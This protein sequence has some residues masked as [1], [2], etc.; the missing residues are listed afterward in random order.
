MPFIRI[1]FMTAFPREVFLKVQR[2][3]RMNIMPIRHWG[4]RSCRHPALFYSII[5]IVMGQEVVYCSACQIRITGREFE[6]GIAF[7]S[8]NRIYCK[9]C[10]KQLPAEER[11]MAEAPPRK[12][13]S[14][15]APREG[16]P[17]TT[18]LKAV[19]SRGA[20]P[21]A[22]K[23]LLLLAAAAGGG[24]LLLS[25]IVV[26]L[27]SGGKRPPPPPPPAV[28][29]TASPVVPADRKKE[30][31]SL[32]QEKGEARREIQRREAEKRALESPKP[33]PE[34]EPPPIQPAPEKA[35]EAPPQV[36]AE[37]P[38]RSAAVKPPE[39]P[40]VVFADALAK[41][42]RN[43]S[44]DSDVD[45]KADEP[46]PGRGTCITFANRKAWA[47]LYL[48]AS[49]AINPIQ[50]PIL[51]FR[52]RSSRP[53]QRYMLGLYRTDA[54]GRDL[55]DAVDMAKLGGYPPAGECKRYEI[56]V[57]RLGAANGRIQ[58]VVFQDHTGAAQPTLY[59]DDLM[60]LPAASGK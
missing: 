24:A 6:C 42:W 12:P 16:P 32:E 15:T 60:F 45:L 19:P 3:P 27:A 59:V 49:V 5:I 48:R 28:P 22:K 7:R 41:G 43:H 38:P 18:R 50:Y 31:E 52:A 33:V 57:D 54:S 29:T 56:P 44:W 10:F 14:E 2:I 20:T 51:S 26:A 1:L 53:G 37:E 17:S 34:V 23:S 8:G 11:A 39:G 4:I 55:K 58:A 9:A 30:A 40:L 35:L 46:A 13:A 21:S 47:G 36:V 25:I